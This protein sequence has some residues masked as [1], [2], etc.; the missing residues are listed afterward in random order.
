M[1]ITVIYK[2]LFVSLERCM[3]MNT[4]SIIEIM[5]LNNVQYYIFFNEQFYGFIYLTLLQNI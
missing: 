4:I 2:N 3:V 5:H 1:A